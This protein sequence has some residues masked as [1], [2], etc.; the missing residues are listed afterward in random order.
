MNGFDI[1]PIGM[2][3][4]LMDK[5]AFA[6]MFPNAPPAACE[7]LQQ[8]Y[9]NRGLLGVGPPNEPPLRRHMKSAKP[10]TPK[11]STMPAAVAKKTEPPKAAPSAPSAPSTHPFVASQPRYVAPNLKAF[12]TPDA[13]YRAG[14][15]VQATISRLTQRKNARAEVY[16]KSRGIDVLAIATTGS[17][18][19]GGYVV[20]D[21]LSQAIITLKARAGQARKLAFIAPMQSGALTVPWEQDG[22]TVEYVGEAPSVAP[23]A[24]D[25]DWGAINFNAKTR[26]VL[27]YV[28]HEL[29]DDALI[30]FVDAYADRAAHALAKCEDREYILGDGTSPYGGEV[31]LIAALGAGGVSTAVTAHDSFVEI[32]VTDFVNCMAKLPEA[33][34]DGRESWICSAAFYAVGMLR[35]VGGAAQGFAEDGRPLF[36]GKPVN[37]FPAMPSSSAASTVCALYG[38]WAEVSA[39]GDRGLVYTFSDKTPTAFERDLIAMKAFSRYDI[40][41]HN[42][43]DASTAGGYVALKTAAS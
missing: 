20:P 25:I 41:I 15:A 5:T 16:C 32:D 31:G 22:L 23:T 2:P 24:S 28:S 11:G 26:G 35:S 13:A 4:Q 1:G 8:G 18:T 42:H 40:S 43:G 34:A 10:A 9:R 12:A 37:L 14:M 19:G 30:R 21:E 29:S 39:I 3:M 33:F 17:P 38:N 6:K 27:G 36:L 7:A